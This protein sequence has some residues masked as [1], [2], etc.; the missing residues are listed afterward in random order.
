VTRVRVAS[1][2]ASTTLVPGD[3]LGARRA[4]ALEQRPET[5]LTPQT[6]EEPI[7]PGEE[8]VVEHAQLDI[9]LEPAQRVL[10][11]TGKGVAVRELARKHL[12]S[13]GRGFERRS[14][15][16]YGLLGLDVE[17]AGPNTVIHQTAVG[18]ITGTLA[19]TFTDK[20]KVVI[21]PSGK[22]NAHFTITCVCTVDGKQGVLEIVAGDTGELLSPTLAAFA[23]R[24]VIKGGTG[25]LSGLR[26]VLQIEGTVNVTTG[27]ATYG[28]TG[29]IH[30]EP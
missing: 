11:L 25:A 14:D 13:A 29:N 9:T 27:R 3:Q 16:A 12:A 21:H 8:L 18:A 5:L 15:G 30:L 24:A 22:F 6:I 7:V 23:G 26:G 1:A 4:H 20:L 19:G 10:I 2:M 17:T 28:Y